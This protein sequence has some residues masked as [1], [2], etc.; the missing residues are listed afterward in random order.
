VLSRSALSA[1][2]I[3]RCISAGKK[4]KF[5]SF[6]S[7]PV[8]EFTDLGSLRVMVYEVGPSTEVVHWCFSTSHRLLPSSCPVR[9][10]VVWVSTLHCIQ[11]VV[12]FFICAYISG[13]SGCT[14]IVGDWGSA[15]DSNGGANSAPHNHSWDQEVLLL[16]PLREGEGVKMIYAAGWKRPSHHH[17]L[18]T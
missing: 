15:P 14:K 10:T 5:T 3:V 16:R 12:V 13:S 2:I 9:T 17:C 8:F 7:S 6:E 11:A 1:F 4:Y 18:L